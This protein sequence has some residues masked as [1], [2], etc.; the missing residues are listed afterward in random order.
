MESRL[1][2]ISTGGQHEHHTITQDAKRRSDKKLVRTAGRN[3]VSISGQ[4][5]GVAPTAGQALLID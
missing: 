1:Y 2:S 5:R 3:A 4:P